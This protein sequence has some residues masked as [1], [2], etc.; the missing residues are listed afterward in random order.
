MSEVG[1]EASDGE[2]GG[3]RGRCLG[4]W[5]FCRYQALEAQGQCDRVSS[6]TEG[7]A[8]AWQ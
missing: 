5:S 3:F 7:T 8:Q 2:Q 1:E 6:L 4:L